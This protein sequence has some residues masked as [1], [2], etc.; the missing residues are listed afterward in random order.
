[1]IESPHH[2][3]LLA[4]IEVSAPA[5]KAHRTLDRS[6]ADALA[7]AVAEDLAHVVPAVAC[8]RLMLGGCLLEPTELLRP[9]FPAWQALESLPGSA[10]ATPGIVAVGSHRGRMPAAA[11]E[12][13]PGLPAGAMLAVPLLLTVPHAEADALEST[14]EQELFE[15]AALR[16]PSL[17]QIAATGFQPIHGQL[18]TANDLLALVRVQLAAAGLDPFWPPVEH[19]LV[20]PDNPRSFE[21]PAGLTAD[22]GQDGLRFHFRPFRPAGQDAADYILWMRAFRQTTALADAHGV[23]WQ[24]ETGLDSDPRGWLVDDRGPDA[25]PDRAVAQSDADTGVI[26]WS[27]CRDGFHTDC[28]PLTSGAAQRLQRQLADD[29]GRQPESTAGLCYDS[30]GFRIPADP[31]DHSR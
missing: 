6:Q 5:A 13:P 28:Y 4:A 15:R 19:A 2:I 3:R 26:A 7:G 16:P 23:P 24:I 30:D 12:A 11:L 1:M 9:G 14:L 10:Q 20:E 8:G 27:V 21:L 25:G 18:M 31:D 22:Y 17:A 29:F